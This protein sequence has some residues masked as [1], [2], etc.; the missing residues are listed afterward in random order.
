MA[1]AT[2]L[3][4]VRRTLR[5]R[6]AGTSPSAT[7]TA[8]STWRAA[9]LSPASR[10]VKVSARAPGT[11][12]GDAACTAISSSTYNGIPSPRVMICSS[13]ARSGEAVE[14]CGE[15]AHRVL[16]EWAQ[17]Q[18]LTEGDQPGE[19]ARALGPGGGH[20]HQPT[21]ADGGGQEGDQVQRRRVRPV[22]V[23]QDEAHQLLARKLQD[24]VLDR[25]EHAVTVCVV[26]TGVGERRVKRAQG[27]GP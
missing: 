20:E 5:R 6:S 1:S 26:R 27:R 14:V 8:S 13:R 11:P 21:G 18:Q 12:D 23:L 2:A 3:R 22:R 24:E 25:L 17:R 19:P 16:G 4:L 9:W 15:L 7:A 10:A